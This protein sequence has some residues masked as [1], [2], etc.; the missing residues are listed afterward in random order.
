MSEELFQFKHAAFLMPLAKT[1]VLGGDGH[2]LG[3]VFQNA[4]KLLL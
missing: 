1:E 2:T 4:Y 3:M